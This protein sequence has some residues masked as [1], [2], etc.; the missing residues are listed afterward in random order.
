MEKKSFTKDDLLKIV[1]QK[2]VIIWGARMTGIGFS[3][4]IESNNLE[5]PICFIDSDKSLHNKIINGIT[6]KSPIELLEL[7]EKYPNL[8][9]V[10]AVALKEKDIIFDLQQLGFDEHS[11]L[12]YSNYCKDFYTIDIVGTCNLKCP[13]CAHG[14]SD[15]KSP[16]G[17]MSYDNF[18]KVVQKALKESEIISHIGLYSWGEPLLHKDLPKIINFLH[19][20]GIAVAISSNLSIKSTI[21]VENL[22]KS[23]PDYLK[24]SIS[25]F[26]EEAYNDTHTG[27]NIYLVKSNLYRIKYL[28]DK[29]KISTLVDVNYHLY[30]NNCNKNLKMMEELCK[31]LGF[32]LSTTYSLIMPLE[33]VFNHLDGNSTNEDLILNDKLLVSMKEGIEISSKINIDTCPF[34]QNQ[35]NI[36]WDLSVPVCCLVFNRNDGTIVSKNFLDISL[37][38]LEKE[39][40]KVDLCNKCMSASLPQ[41]NM[42]FNKKGWDN[43]ASKKESFDN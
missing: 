15:M 6:I 14:A 42:G 5:K 31:E 11:Y 10:I 20:K 23:N 29:Y 43:I 12:L 8:L 28:I 19:E 17:F 4:F 27:G 25:G 2:T 24:I 36:N 32:S 7:K 22:I 13:S 9:I 34:K 40:N 35:I 3:R 41:Y 30:N 1:Q 38:E 21:D 26:Y 33:R 37:S 39:K 18:Q 16:L